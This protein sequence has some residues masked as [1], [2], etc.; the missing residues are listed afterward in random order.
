MLFTEKLAEKNKR[1]LAPPVTAAFLG[2]S[3]THGCFELIAA[4][5]GGFDCIYDQQSAYHN[6]LKKV[7][8]LK[9]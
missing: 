6:L 3:V 9:I 2:D 7:L 8:F 1:M 5:G 4:P